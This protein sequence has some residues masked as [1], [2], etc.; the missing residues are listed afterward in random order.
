MWM[1]LIPQLKSG[2]LVVAL[3]NQ[4]VIISDLIAELA[5]RGPVTVLDRAVSG[6]VGMFEKEEVGLGI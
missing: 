1:N 6:V 5:L 4:N 3:T 2:R